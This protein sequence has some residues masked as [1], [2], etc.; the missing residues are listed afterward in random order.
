MEGPIAKKWL[1]AAERLLPRM[2]FDLMRKDLT[3]LQEQCETIMADSLRAGSDS[4][5]V[6]DRLRTSMTSVAETL[7]PEFSFDTPEEERCR[8]SL[9]KECASLMPKLVQSLW[10]KCAEDLLRSQGKPV[11]AWGR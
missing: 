1:Q 3:S 4:K 5:D 2:E 8:E 6:E 9:V 11:F 10:R 7:L